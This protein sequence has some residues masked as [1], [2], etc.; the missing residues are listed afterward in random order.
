MDSTRTAVRIDKWLWAAR[1]FKT[2]VLAQKSCEIG[3]IESN[4]HL[5]K[6]ARDVRIGDMLK[7][8][9]DAAEFEVEVMLL[10]EMRGPASVAQTLYRETEPSKELRLKLAAEL[11]ALQQ[12]EGYLPAAKPS[13]R[14]RRQINRF[15]GRV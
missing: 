7:I 6:P 14:D 15:R 13:K 11:K 12:V 4:G 8:K 5:A 9:N 3:R 1:F 10:S 2:R